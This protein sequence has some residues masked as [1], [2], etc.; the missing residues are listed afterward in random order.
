MLSLRQP[1][2]WVQSWL[3]RCL[4]CS[5]PLHSLSPVVAGAVDAVHGHV[6]I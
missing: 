5:Q 1:S 2:L 4:G 6:D 3:E